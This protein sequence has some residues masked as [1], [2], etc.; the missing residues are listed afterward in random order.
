MNFFSF[1]VKEGNT[2][3]WQKM[4]I[5]LKAKIGFSEKCPFYAKDMHYLHQR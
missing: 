1:T 3:S 5:L 2:M 4:K